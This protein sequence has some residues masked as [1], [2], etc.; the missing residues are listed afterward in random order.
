MERYVLDSLNG[1]DSSSK[2][3]DVQSLLANMTQAE[4]LSLCSTL[5]EAK[6][7]ELGLYLESIQKLK[8]DGDRVTMKRIQEHVL[9]EIRIQ[10]L[11]KS[12]VERKGEL[13]VLLKEFQSR[14][15]IEDGSDEY[16]KCNVRQICLLEA[17]RQAGLNSMLQYLKDTAEELKD[18]KLECS[19]NV[20][21]I[22]TRK[23]QVSAQL[24]TRANY[25]K[26]RPL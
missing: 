23:Q 9:N 16:G 4:F 12:V 19:T 14:N 10:K 18:E 13:D 26:K 15:S 21:E 20:D 25:R 8:G 1:V 17:L 11:K 2:L 24:V 3:Q 22:I 6:F 7:L 5:P